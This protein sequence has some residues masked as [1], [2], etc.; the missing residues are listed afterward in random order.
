MVAGQLAEFSEHGAVH[1]DDDIGPLQHLGSDLGASVGGQVVAEG[2]G[3][4]DHGGGGGV[5]CLGRGPAG[6]GG[7]PWGGGRGG[8]AGGGGGG[9][10]R[11][12][13]PRQTTR[14]RQG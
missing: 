6:A 11:Q 4:L 13:L 14:I 2:G 7:P 9:G 1:G 12:W 5:A 3:G 8:G 10:E